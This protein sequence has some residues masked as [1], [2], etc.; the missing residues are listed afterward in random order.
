MTDGLNLS[1]EIFNL[2]KA[3]VG[4]RDR[5][6]LPDSPSAQHANL[7][8]DPRIKNDVVPVSPGRCCDMRRVRHRDEPA[9]PLAHYGNVCISYRLLRLWELLTSVKKRG[10]GLP[11]IL[12][13]TL[14]V[15]H[16]VLDVSGDCVEYRYNMTLV[17][18][19]VVV[20]EVQSQGR[21]WSS[22]IKVWKTPPQ[23]RFR[24]RKPGPRFTFSLNSTCNLQNMH[25]LR[26]HRHD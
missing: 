15:G 17:V 9:R 13:I 20:V 7:A 12:C 22:R 8:P 2:R 14:Q 10:F 3:G 21:D 6:L 23:V 19:V 1:T 26:R 11:C 16:L 18:A 4:R 25:R 24:S 5:K